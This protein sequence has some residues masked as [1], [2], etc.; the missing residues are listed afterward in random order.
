MV[1][2]SR[3]VSGFSADTRSTHGTCYRP[4]PAGV[5][6][7][8]AN[9]VA[10]TAQAS[11]PCAGLT[12]ARPATIRA[13]TVRERTPR[14]GDDVG[15]FVPRIAHRRVGS[16]TVAAPIGRRAHWASHT[17][18]RPTRQHHAGGRRYPG[19]YARGAGQP[20]GV[21]SGRFG[22][23]RH[24][25]PRMSG[26]PTD[27][28][29]PDS[30]KP[31]KRPP[32]PPPSSKPP[33]R[34]PPPPPQ[35]A[36]P[37]KSISGTKKSDEAGERQEPGMSKH[38]TVFRLTPVTYKISLFYL[39]PKRIRHAAA[40]TSG[41]HCHFELKRGNKELDPLE[42]LPNIVRG[43]TP[44]D[45][46]EPVAKPLDQGGDSRTPD[47]E[48]PYRLIVLDNHGSRKGDDMTG[49]GQDTESRPANYTRHNFDEDIY[50]D[51][52]LRVVVRK[53]VGSKQVDLDPADVKVLWEIKDSKE[54]TSRIGNARAR[55]F[56]EKFL[57]DDR[58]DPAKECDDNASETYGGY[59]PPRASGA[60]GVKA[61]KVLFELPYVPQ[62]PVARLVAPPTPEAEGGGSSG[63]RKKKKR[64]DTAPSPSP[65]ENVQDHPE[66]LTPVTLQDSYRGVT[67][68]TPVDE[69]L[70][71][72]KTVKVGVSDVL[73]R[74]YPANGDDYRFLLRLVDS[75]GTDI[76]QTKDQQ[77]TVHL[78]D[79]ARQ[80]IPEPRCYTTH[81]VMMWRK[82]NIGLLVWTNAVSTADIDWD[83]A[84]RKYRD[85][86]I[87][88]TGPD[89]VYE[90]TRAGWRQ[91]LK[92]YFSGAGVG[93]RARDLSKRRNYPKSDFE[94]HLFPTFLLSPPDGW[95]SGDPDNQRQT[96][97]RADLRYEHLAKLTRQIIAD[98]CQELGLNAPGEAT[99]QMYMPG[100]CVFLAR[101]LW[102]RCSLLGRYITELQFYV[103]NGRDATITFSHE[104]GH[105][106]YLRHGI[107]ST[108]ELWGCTTG[109]YKPA[110]GTAE[111]VGFYSLKRNCYPFDHDQNNCID[112]LMSYDNDN[113]PTN[114]CA[115][116]LLTLRHYD[117]L[118][119]R[120]GRKTDILA[121]A[122]PAK[123]MRVTRPTGQKTQVIEDATP[124]VQRGKIY[125]V[126]TIGKLEPNPNDYGK[127]VKVLDT[128]DNTLYRIASKPDG[129]G[130]K[131]TINNHFNV[132]SRIEVAADAKPGTYKIEFVENG[133]VRA[134][135][136]L[137]VT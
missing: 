130:D 58:L 96:D 86:Y 7:G 128:L 127:V 37:K 61:D 132:Y 30:S 98:T 84:K 91:A 65:L 60:P 107:T 113:I 102:D 69:P 50:P 71:G 100:Y 72:D 1:W 120:N 38:R 62:P 26:S 87:E 82:I 73:F 76:R 85:A 24:D 78:A 97:W 41:Y 51:V 83:V 9:T 40:N 15:A 108:V 45:D 17:D 19:S 18:W 103:K 70:S 39:G 126:A 118:A 53:F 81:Q 79:D 125:R 11:G 3:K 122:L 68:L 77:R 48:S 105:G 124:T 31:P 20:T 14:L 54:W 135:M 75:S 22:V 29:K 114:L 27:P 4:I 134:S 28:D 106:L 90:L 93:I 95:H 88:L 129:A 42:V 59:R 5:D 55:Q 6:A 57:K 13:A 21:G 43:K 25:G 101:Q 109:K 112:C 131:V 67:T 92:K 34:P 63:R 35:S 123:I 133:T 80:E 47:G 52:P 23:P 32:P 137:T 56:I 10:R 116:C 104:L 110:G 49:A 111:D 119:M 74:P 117:T 16:L 89:R 121:G 33:K 2:R 36:K 99:R 46:V 8:P 136:D 115:M 66:P 64:R 94:A 12:V 44:D